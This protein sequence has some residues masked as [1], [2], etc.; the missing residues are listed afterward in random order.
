MLDEKARETL[1]ENDRGGYTIPCRDLYPFQWNWDSAL[2]APGWLTFDEP[3]AWRELETLFSGQWPSGKIPHIIFHEQ[4]D[5]YFPCPKIW[6]TG[7]E[8][9]SSGITQPPV[10]ATMLR[11]IFEDATDRELAREKLET[12]FDKALAFNR[13]FHEYRD[14]DATGL[15]A[16]YH[17]W[18][19]GRDNAIDWQDALMRVSTEGLEPYERR[20]LSH[21]DASQRPTDE[22]YDRYI[23]LLQLFRDFNYDSKKLYTQTPFKMADP[24]INAILIRADRD[25]LHLAGLLGRDDVVAEIEA[26]L[27]VS[28]PAFER[29]WCEE[30][31]AF[32][33]LDL[34]TGD[35]VA[36]QTSAAYLAFFA[37]AGTDAQRDALVKRLRE[38]MERDFYLVPSLSPDDPRFDS[39]RYWLGPVWAVVNYLIA[40]GLKE[41]GHDDIAARIAADTRRLIE[42]SG[43]MEYFDPGTGEGLGGDTFSWT[44]AMWLCWLRHADAGEQAAQAG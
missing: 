13:W 21:V 39:K 37:G 11:R 41:H 16:I 36:A 10:A 17:P 38:L 26:R 6:R 27:A 34:L 35:H 20:D 33:S 12:L 29:L 14:P 31:Q 4:S 15:V 25:M 18:E 30:A 5:S 32:C 2:C 28:V 3:R 1:R 22:Q 7:T 19:S 42:T 40:T 9:P 43:F 44:A 23:S 24:G 8:I